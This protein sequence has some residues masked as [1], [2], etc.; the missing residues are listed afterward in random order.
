MFLEFFESGEERD[1]GFTQEI[2]NYSSLFVQQ[3]KIPVKVEE[4]KVTPK[5]IVGSGNEINS[6]WE[7]VGK[8]VQKNGKTIVYYRDEKNQIRGV[9]E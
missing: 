4:K 3:K 2:S 6:A 1:R 8:V 5:R 7:Q 9:E